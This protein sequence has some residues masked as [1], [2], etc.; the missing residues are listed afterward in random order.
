MNIGNT[1]IAKLHQL[2]IGKLTQNYS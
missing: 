1:P 2:K